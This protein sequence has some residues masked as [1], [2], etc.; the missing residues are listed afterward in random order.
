MEQHLVEDLQP[1]QRQSRQR[2]VLGPRQ[3]AEVPL[4][5]GNHARAQ[6]RGELID[7][8]VP[9][10]DPDVCVRHHDHH[11][12]DTVGREQVV[13]DEVGCTLLHPISVIAAASVHQLQCRVILVTTTVSRW[14]VDLHP[15]LRAR[16]PRGVVDRAHLAVRH[17]IVGQEISLN[18]R[19]DEDRD[20]PWRKADPA[21]TGCEVQVSASIGSV[22]VA[23]SI[24]KS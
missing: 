3:H 11:R 18:P 12:H 4:D 17:R 1:T 15:T 2:S 6:L 24:T 5:G 23:P 16:D 21:G 9:G 20:G 7:R 13:Q 19:D 8:R 14:R 10:R 22:T